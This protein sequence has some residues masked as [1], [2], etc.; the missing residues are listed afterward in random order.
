MFPKGVYSLEAINELKDKFPYAV[1]LLIYAV[2]E[3]CLKLHLL[4]SRKTLT[5]AEVNLEDKVNEAVSDRCLA[6]RSADSGT[7]R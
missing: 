5:N 7:A 2:L 4:E 1:T 6:L 3:R